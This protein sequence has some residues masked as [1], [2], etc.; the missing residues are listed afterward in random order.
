MTVLKEYGYEVSF[1]DKSTENP[2]TIL[3]VE[4]SDAVIL[5]EEQLVSKTQLVKSNISI[6]EKAGKKVLGFILC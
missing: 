3:E 2:K 5:L 6:S 4:N 1:I